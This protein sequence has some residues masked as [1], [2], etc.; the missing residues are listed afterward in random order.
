MKAILGKKIG[1]SQIF[2]PAGVV[3]P[4]TLV[5]AEPNAVMLRR[6]VARDGH[7]AVQV[8]LAKRPEETKT[9]KY[10][11][12]LKRAWEARME[13]KLDLAED[14]MEVTLEQFAVGD[15]IEVVGVAKGKGFQGVVKRHH[16]KGGPKSHGH[17]HVLRR[18][19]SIGSRFPQHT[20]KGM[21]MA[22]R[23]GSERV[24]VKNLEIV[25]IDAEKNMVA[26]KGAL[27][28]KRGSV[29]VIKSI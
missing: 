1:M 28:G 7:D 16:F 4:V 24:T 6:S 13:F 10:P 17:R 18:P 25:A 8:G 29:L 20:M 22:G 26:I 5:L 27:P 19:G 9:A 21:R 2:T 14:V 12:E 15:R 3:I 11:N 23:M